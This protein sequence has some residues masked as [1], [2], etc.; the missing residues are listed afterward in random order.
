MTAAPVID[1]NRNARGVIPISPAYFARL[2]EMP[3]SAPPTNRHAKGMSQ[4]FLLESIR[5]F[6]VSFIR[7]PVG[8]HGL[9]Y[10][11]IFLICIIQTITSQAAHLSQP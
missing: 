5:G 6:E 9:D 10:M 11:A 8:L 3:I 1:Q 4:A 7:Y 2:V